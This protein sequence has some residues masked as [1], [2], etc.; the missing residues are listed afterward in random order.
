MLVSL[1][2]YSKTGS[3]FQVPVKSPCHNGMSLLHCGEQECEVLTG[4]HAAFLSV[5]V[6]LNLVSIC[7]LSS[8]LH[9]IADG[10]HFNVN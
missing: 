6:Y 5:Q 9:V 10:L 3:K 8:Q 7:Y 2:V 1:E 4:Y